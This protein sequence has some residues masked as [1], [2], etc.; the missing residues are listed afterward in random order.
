M[1]YYISPTWLRVIRDVKEA[2]AQ[3]PQ[4][5]RKIT[6]A[7]GLLAQSQ[8]CDRTPLYKQMEYIL[9]ENAYFLYRPPA[10]MYVFSTILCTFIA[11][12]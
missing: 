8:K 1:Y 11:K 9:E 3:Q 4:A 12:V 2:E 5:L 7:I 10:G 6:R